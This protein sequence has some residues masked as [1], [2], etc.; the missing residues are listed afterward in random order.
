MP[1]EV[2]NARLPLRI[3]QIV[4]QT[5]LRDF[6][7]HIL[8]TNQIQTNLVLVFLV[9]FQPVKRWLIDL[10]SLLIMLLYHLIEHTRRVEKFLLTDFLESLRRAAWEQSLT[11]VWT[12][13]VA[14]V[15]APGLTAIYLTPL[16]NVASIL[17]A[18][19][20]RAHPTALVLTLLLT[21]AL[22]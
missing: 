8:V 7:C 6:I 4:L 10:L 12:P 9:L 16:A 14:F 11:P 13:R 5:S 1:I 2:L 21:L 15:L 17:V 18:S 20:G 3:L 22:S 19:S